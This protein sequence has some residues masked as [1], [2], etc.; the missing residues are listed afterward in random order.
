MKYTKKQYTVE[1]SA[2][3]QHEAENMHSPNTIS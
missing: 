1:F 3:R 2:Y